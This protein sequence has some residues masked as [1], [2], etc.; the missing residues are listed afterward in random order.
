ML[1]F[2]AN[3][4][5]FDLVNYFHRNL[6]NLLIGKFWGTGQLGLYSRAY[7]LLMF[8]IQ[9]VR[10]PINAV[11]FPAL[12]K[13]QNNP[14]AF[15]NYYRRITLATAAISMPVAACL[16]V[17]AEPLI[18]IA[19]GVRW[20]PSAAIFQILALVAF[21]QPSST[22]RGVVVMSLGQGKCYLTLGILQA[23]FTSVGF[24]IGVSWGATGVAI[25]YVISTWLV[26][27]FMFRIAFRDAPVDFMD[28][29]RAVRNPAFA[30]IV[31]ALVAWLLARYSLPSSLHAAA[32]LALVSLA[33]FSVYVL[34]FAA[35]RDNRAALLMILKSLSATGRHRQQGI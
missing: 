10:G 8:P 19:L 21:I 26:M 35:S 23:A 7:A 6:D 14:E 32:R 22:L 11:A 31:A 3:V 4:T 33:F 2:G 12:S 28:F 29:I 13:L 18:A 27:P 9:A 1:K 5:A 16:F 15:R 17:V 30:A 34:V 20:L 25:S 24:C